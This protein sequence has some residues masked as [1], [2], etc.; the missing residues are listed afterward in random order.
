MA[1]LGTLQRGSYSKSPIGVNC[2]AC[3]MYMLMGVV[4]H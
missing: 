4:L 3:A 2:R 1:G